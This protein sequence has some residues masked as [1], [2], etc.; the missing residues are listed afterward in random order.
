M[1]IRKTSGVRGVVRKQREPSEE[2]WYRVQQPDLQL[3]T[4]TKTSM[5]IQ[6][7]TAADVSEAGES[8]YQPQ[9]R[10]C[11]RVLRDVGVDRVVREAEKV[12]QQARAFGRQPQVGVHRPR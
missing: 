10:P 4:R 2:R 3:S 5:P 12:P 1:S 11:L 8:W 6:R 7:T 9:G